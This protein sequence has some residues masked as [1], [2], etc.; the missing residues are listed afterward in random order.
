M[1]LSKC[2]MSYSLGVRRRGPDGQLMAIGMDE[3]IVKCVVKCG[4]LR[5][6]E[7]DILHFFMHEWSLRIRVLK[8]TNKVSRATGHAETV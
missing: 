7:L 1:V 8:L 4:L 3:A 5:R 2:C 6:C